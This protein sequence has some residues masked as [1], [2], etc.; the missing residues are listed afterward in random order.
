[1]KTAYVI[2]ARNKMHLAAHV[3]RCVRSAFVQTHAPLEII[4]SDQGS[5]DGTRQLFERLAAEYRGPHTVRVLDCPDI[6][7]KGMAGLNAH[8]AWLHNTL[9]ADIFIASSADDYAHPQRAEKIVQAFERT[10]ADMVGSAMLFEDPTGAA[11][12]S[13]SGHNRDGWVSVH[14]VVVNRV[15]GSCAPA[16]RRSLW[17]RLIPIPALCGVDVWMPP[18]A[19]A[20]GGLWYI[21]EPLYTY[22]M[23]ADPQN[24]GL[25]GVMKALPE[26]ERRPVDEHRM[27][28][29]ATAWQWVLRRMQQMGI[30]APDERHVVLQAAIAHYEA[31]GDVRTAMTVNRESPRPF[32]I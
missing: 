3:E 24:T 14:D 5:T 26:G 22:I 29:I 32:L 30:G 2:F 16:W 10:G 19:A 27:F 21:N 20:L 28:Q 11:P 7:Y 4:L 12:L 17:D 6:T 13:R 1:M 31:W 18:I 23:H 8:L 15:G 9:D 25:E